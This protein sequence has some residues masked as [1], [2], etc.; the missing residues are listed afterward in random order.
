MSSTKSWRTPD[1]IGSNQ[2]FILPTVQNLCRI[3]IALILFQLVSLSFDD[4]TP[5]R[6][7]FLKKILD[8]LKQQQKLPFSPLASFFRTFLLPCLLL[9]FQTQQ[10]LPR[11]LVKP[12]YDVYFKDEPDTQVQLWCTFQSYADEHLVIILSSVFHHCAM[13][14]QHSSVAYKK[15]GVSH[16]VYRVSLAFMPHKPFLLFT[17]RKKGG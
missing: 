11:V 9:A 2:E 5:E 1:V 17:V 14:R 13:L 12:F 4:C 16:C 8:D 10:I 3:E 6:K 15:T 7:K